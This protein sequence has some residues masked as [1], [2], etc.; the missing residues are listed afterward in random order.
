[1][2]ETQTPL[3]NQRKQGENSLAKVTRV[4]DKINTLVQTT[5]VRSKKQLTALLI[6]LRQKVKERA[7]VVLE[8]ESP[9]TQ[10]QMIRSL[11]VHLLNFYPLNNPIQAILLT[12]QSLIIAFPKLICSKNWLRKRNSISIKFR[13]Q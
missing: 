12:L 3:P 10:A 9:K 11:K 6:M 2:T 13:T 7:K 4:I 1:M 5:P 8:K